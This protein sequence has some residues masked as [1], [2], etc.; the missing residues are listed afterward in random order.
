M[1]PL[2]APFEE[3][4]RAGGAVLAIQIGVPAPEAFRA[5]P[6]VVFQALERRFSIRVAGA[7]A[8]DA[9]AV[10]YR[11]RKGKP[12]LQYIF[13]QDCHAEQYA[14]L[15]KNSK[16]NRSFESVVKMR[17]GLTEAELRECFSC[18]TTGYGRP[19]GFQSEAK[20]P[21]RKNAGCEVCHGPGSLHAESQD[22]R[23]IKGR[24]SVANCETC[25]NA[26]RVGA[27]KYRPMIYEGAH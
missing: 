11:D 25:H 21:Q 9:Q 24:L 15:V 13:R 19:G 22:P 10:P 16:K 18:H 8:H 5:H 12:P 4:Y 1:L 27:F 14:S 7:F 6:D 3:P 17:K 23:D 20:T 2:A 26:E